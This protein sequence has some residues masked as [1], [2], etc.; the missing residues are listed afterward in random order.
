MNTTG[1][2]EAFL[3]DWATA[4]SNDYSGCADS[5]DTASPVV[6]INE[7]SSNAAYP[8]EYNSQVAKW[9][10]VLGTQDTDADSGS[11]QQ[12]ALATYIDPGANP[13]TWNRLIELPSDKVSVLVAN[14][15][16]GPDSAVNTGWTDVL[17]RV[18][19]S[20]KTV[21]GYVR[22]GYLGGSFQHFTTRL[23]SSLTSDWVAQIQEDVDQWCRLYPGSM[24]GIFFDEG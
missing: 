20:G 5:A 11:G 16:N 15:V 1:S 18:K 22:T 24:G 23:G 21:L 13:D 7:F 9:I 12:I 3:S 14:V 17:P 6:R 10:A 19:A 4:A 2:V 8:E